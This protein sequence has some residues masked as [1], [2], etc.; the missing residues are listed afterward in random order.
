[1]GGDRIIPSRMSPE[2]RLL[3]LKELFTYR[4]AAEKTSGPL[5]LDLGCGAGYGTRILSE[6]FGSAV[7]VDISEDAVKKARSEYERN[8]C[9]FLHYD[10]RALPFPENM[11]DTVVSFHVIE[12]VKDA[13]Q[14]LS[15]ACRVLKKGGTFI[16]STPN[17]ALRISEGETPW[18]VFHVREYT[19]GEFRGILARTFSEITVYGVTAVDKVMEIEKKRIVHNRKLASYDFL[20]LRRI[21]PAWLMAFPVALAHRIGPRSAVETPVDINMDPALVYSVGEASV[22]T[23]LDIMA[24]CRK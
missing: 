8:N 9:D 11:F 10:G 16:I 18:N 2:E 14:F 5:C 7:G 3:F 1:M 13:K 12:H 17:A 19:F 21:I 23:S 22:K 24:V 4:W 6:K 20:G 15:E